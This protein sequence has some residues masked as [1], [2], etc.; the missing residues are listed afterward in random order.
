MI[1]IPTW[2]LLLILIGA[3][4]VY[5]YALFYILIRFK[6]SIYKIFIVVILA[7]I[8]IKL[9]GILLVIHG[10]GVYETAK[11]NEAQLRKNLQRFTS[12]SPKQY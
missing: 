6:R 4:I 9:L 10:T 11:Q 3:S 5:F 2:V 12:P 7:I 8:G 1:T